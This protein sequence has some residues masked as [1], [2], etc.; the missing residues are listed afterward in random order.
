MRQERRLRIA[1]VAPPWMAV[2]PSG[3]GGI[4]MIVDLLARGL[5][6]RGH[7][8]TLFAPQGSR[9][10]A[11]VVSPLPAAG[12]ASIG[13]PWFEAYHALS[14]HGQAGEFD[15]VH[16]HTFLGPAFARMNDGGATTV[17]TLHG[18]WEQRARAYYQ[19]VH[20]RVH[21]VAISDTQR[22]ANPEL[23]Y[24]A[25]IPNG[26]D[27]GAY[28]LA[29]GQREDFL[30]YI[31]RANADKA[32]E[33]AVELAHRA[34]RPLKLLCKRAE[35]EER[36][37]WEEQ[38]APR[39]GPDDEALEDVSHE[40]KL[41]LLGRGAAFVF[42]IRWEEPFGLVMI[43]ALACGMPVVATPRGAA[44]EIVEDGVTGFLRD[45]PDGLVAALDELDRI[46]PADCR[47]RVE[48]RFSAEAMVNRYEELFVAL[49]A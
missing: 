22:C 49:A 45:N 32:P 31:G 35:P 14:A 11:E 27:L 16:D 9:S 10:T 17:H 30:V 7:E 6:D 46:S 43:E 28:P 40:A 41:E 39:L 26:I 13:D 38:V 33:L 44:T 12:A 15:L 4:E 8:V 34:G 42:P 29:D 25:T 37:Y 21:L 18:P 5:T 20:E 48:R 36:R 1:Q 23:P 24:A 2:P 3:Y 47:A 19:L